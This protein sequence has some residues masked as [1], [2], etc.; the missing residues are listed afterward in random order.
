MQLAMRMVGSIL[1][2][3]S[4]L[5][6]VRILLGW[7]PH[8]YFGRV[9]GFLCR[10][11]DPYLNYFRRFIFLRIGNIDLS[12][13]AAIALLSVATNISG[14]IASSGGVS[15]GLVLALVLNAVWS[16]VSFIIGF[17]A[18]VIGLRLAAYF[19]RSNIYSGFWRIVEAIASPI[20][21]RAR[22]VFFKGRDASYL[23]NLVVSLIVLLALLAGLGLGVN[24]L[25]SFLI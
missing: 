22:Q 14:T 24:A 11:C 12:P 19:M 7:F 23:Q 18:C 2:F 16:A 21:Y 17:F 8:F 4:L 9:Y 6:F 15:L 25:T 5:I 1:S 13:I 10:V 3:Y 20:L